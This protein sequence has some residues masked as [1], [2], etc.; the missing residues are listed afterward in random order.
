MK[1]FKLSPYA[2]DDIRSIW[3]YI[4]KD[5]VRAARRVRLRIF[6]ACTRLAEHPRIGHERGDLTDRHLLFWT[7]EPY[8][9]VYNPA[10]NPIEIVRVLHGALDIPSILTEL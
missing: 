2:A 10:R 9:I 3:S 5:N 6:D 7:V 1:S 4:A 8:L